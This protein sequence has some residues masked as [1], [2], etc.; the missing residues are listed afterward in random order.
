MNLA[1]IE[2]LTKRLF[3]KNTPAAIESA[4]LFASQSDSA[5]GY[6]NEKPSRKDLEEETQASDQKRDKDITG[7]A[8]GEEIANKAKDEKENASITEPDTNL[9]GDT[10]NL[11]IGQTDLGASGTGA[12]DL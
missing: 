2:L 4:L 7:G 5:G 3:G 9:T 1:Q 12:E 11:D 8:Q 10:G 6:G